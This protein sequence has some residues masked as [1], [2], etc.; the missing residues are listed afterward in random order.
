[1][2]TFD[3]ACAELEAAKIAEAAATAARIDAE[4]AVLA[5][6]E[7][8]PEGSVTQ[9]GHAYKATATFTVNR[10]IDAAALE[11][12]REQIPVPLFEQAVSYKPSLV[13]AGVRYLQQNEPE[14][15]AVLAQA[16]TAKPGKPSVRI[17]AVAGDL[18][19]AA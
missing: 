18:R 9:R 8:K 17:E 13:Q 7:S 14:T 15:Y 3:Q 12:I 16:I 5:E 11:A 1:M 19:E 6:M 10:S 2:N 4:C